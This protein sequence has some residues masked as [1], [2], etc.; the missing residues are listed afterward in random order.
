MIEVYSNNITVPAG[1]A[2]PLENLALK[3]GCTV[4]N[5]GTRTL[6]F[7]KAGVYKVDVSASVVSSTATGTVAI[8]LMKNG[9]LVPNAI[10]TE[11]VG[12]ATGIHALAFSTLVTVPNNNSCCCTNIPTVITVMNN[13]NAATYNNIDVV[14]TK[15]C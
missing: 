9:S 6:Q 15:V 5:S 13:A 1:T 12:D 10:S 11:T 4:T 3:K 7:N 8:Q 2:I 14:I